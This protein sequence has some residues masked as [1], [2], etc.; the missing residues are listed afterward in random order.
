[1]D[2][3]ENIDAKLQQGMEYIQEKRES[4]KGCDIWLEAWEDIKE[5]FAE[6][7]AENVRDLD[8]KHKWSLWVTNYVQFLEMELGNAGIENPVYHTK[9]IEYCHELLQWCGADD[10]LVANTRCAL[11]ESYFASGNEAECDRLFEEWLK[12]DPDWALGYMAW[13]E[14]YIHKEDST[15]YYDKAEE[16]LLA[17]YSRG[18]PHERYEM[19]ANLMAIYDDTGRTEQFKEF[20]KLFKELHDSIPELAEADEVLRKELPNWPQAKQEFVPYEKPVPVRV[21]KIGRNE[22]CPCGSGK[23]YKKC[24]GA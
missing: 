17:G 2:R 18:E 6:G 4:I 8:K 11:A 22:P 16:I 7:F 24:C 23:K 3:L 21:V 19:V 12:N 5:L 10:L 13:A 20:E 14:C 1:V 15:K 9:R